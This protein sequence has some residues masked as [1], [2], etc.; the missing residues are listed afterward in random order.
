MH[1]GERDRTLTADWLGVWALVASKT[2]PPNIRAI[3][4][5]L[6]YLSLYFLD[7]AYIEPQRPLETQRTYKRRE[8]DTLR[9][10]LN[11]E[12]K[13]QEVRVMTLRPDIDW[14]M[15]WGNLHSSRLPD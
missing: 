10:I 8:Y 2:N 13:S 5:S 4:Q 15:V 6:A 9:T 14:T 7:W 1:Q 3:P 11:A 12:T